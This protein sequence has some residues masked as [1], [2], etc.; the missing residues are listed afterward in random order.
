M[1]T[2]PLDPV[3]GS[4][5][6]PHDDHLSRNG[7]SVSHASSETAAFD[8][9]NSE[10]GAIAG[11][12]EDLQ[13]RLERA[14]DQLDQVTTVRTTEYEIGR[15]FLEAQRFSE[16]S[17]S[18]LE[19]QVQEI[20]VEAEAKATQIL[21]EATEE[22]HEIRRRAQQASVIPDRTAQ[23]LHDAILG[24][25]NVNSGL[26]RE[27]NALNGMLMP[28]DQRTY[29]ADPKPHPMD[30]SQNATRS[31]PMDRSQNAMGSY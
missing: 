12:I 17:L 9:A 31:H 24:F 21:L 10:I 5:P 15:L 6:F 22:A 3:F 25:V 30:R 20:L 29:T 18:R 19:V 16:A 11:A 23:E 7:N 13:S 8:T 1:N 26:V 28:A 14:H 27:L 2:N 4:T